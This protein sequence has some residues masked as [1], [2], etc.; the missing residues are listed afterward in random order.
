[1]TAQDD[2]DNFDDE[3]A[4]I[5]EDIGASIDDG[6]QAA[7]PKKGSKLVL[8]IATVFVIGVGGLVAVNSLGLLGGGAKPPVANKTA[9]PQQQQQQTERP[10]AAVPVLDEVPASDLAAAPAL[11]LSVPAPAPDTTSAPA[12]DLALPPAIGA[13]E[14][15]PSIGAPAETVENIIA[16]VNPALQNDPA[17]AIS[18]PTPTA[19]PDAPQA[20]AITAPVMDNITMPASDLAT[21]TLPDA[22]T[23]APATIPSTQPSLPPIETVA[24]EMPEV[25]M[26]PQPVPT[27]DPIAERRAG[28]APD[29]ASIQRALDELK[30]MV[31][32]K[33]DVADLNSRINALEA[34]GVAQQD[35]PAAKSSARRHNNNVSED[36]PVRKSQP[37]KAETAKMAPVDSKRWILK[38]AKPGMA[39][40]AEPGSS[41]IRSVAKGDTVPGLG[42]IKAVVKDSMGKWTIEGSQARVSQ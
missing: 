16:P 35:K 23:P 7:T 6:N 21:A 19:V 32:T 31:A 18:L 42:R 17:P 40:I 36:A 12:L 22:P 8:I 24:P 2:F 20:A 13:P 39:W 38:A 33:Q 11:D 10:S 28:P 37:R 1:M 14:A 3:N 4:A 15:V 5:E 34:A 9:R 29:V 27:H 41:E 25:A 30:D 26:P